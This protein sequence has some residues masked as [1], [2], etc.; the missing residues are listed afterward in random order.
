MSVFFENIEEYYIKTFLKINTININNQENKDSNYIKISN[1]NKCI[2]LCL[3]QEKESQFYFEH[4]FTEKEKTKNIFDIIGK[5]MCSAIL[6]GFNATIISYGKKNTGKT[7]TLLGKSIFEIQKNFHDKENNKNDI[8]YEYLNNKG[9]LI[10]CIENIFNTL[11]LNNYYDNFLYNISLS[12]IEVFDN[13]IID[14]FNIE[15]F[16]DNCAFNYKN[17][18]KK[19]YNTDINFTKLNI[20][21]VDEAFSLLNQGQEIRKSLFN[22]INMQGIKGHLIITFYF[23]KINKETNQIFKSSFNFIEISSSNIIKNNYNITINKSLET[24]SYIINQLSDNVKREN[25]LYRNSLLTNLL[26][27]SLGGNSKTS[28][29]VN[30]TPYKNDAIG[31]FQSLNFSSKFK[32]ILNNP[33]INEIISNNIDYAYYNEIIEKK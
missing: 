2:N 14:Y 6:E 32:N 28:I 17:I 31:S 5:P 30:I 25:I 9:I 13:N 4:I 3:S 15:N 23:E 27:D 1:D 21:S 12:F 11:V 8:Y 22:E 20:S 7:Y 24:F 29:I 16:V 33:K 26:K 19:K 18:F 10:F